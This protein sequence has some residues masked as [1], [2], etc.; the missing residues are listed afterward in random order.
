[1]NAQRTMGLF[2]AT[3]VGVGSIVGGGILALAGTAFAEAGPSAVLAITLNGVIALL[4][5]LSFAELSTRFPESGGSYAFARKALAIEAAFVVG[6]I[7]WFALIA[8]A[9]LYAVGF[10]EFVVIGLEGI[11]QPLAGD[12]PVWMSHRAAVVAAALIP[13]AFCA[14]RFIR[15]SDGGAVWIRVTRRDVAA[16]YSSCSP[17]QVVKHSG[18]MPWLKRARLRWLTYLSTGSQFSS[19]SRIFL[20]AA[21]IE[22]NPLRTFVSA[23]ASSSSER[24]SSVTSRMVAMIRVRPLASSTRGASVMFTQRRPRRVS[25]GV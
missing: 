13:T 7:F 21:Q 17:Y 6:W 14:A 22:T 23:S 11:W 5:A 15:T 8:S 1:M 9:V 20:H 18:H 3:A 10:G 16:R 25:T 24:L 4:T 2:G 12:V 19:S